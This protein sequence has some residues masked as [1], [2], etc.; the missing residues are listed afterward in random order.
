MFRQQIIKP[1]FFFYS[2][3]FE[4]QLPFESEDIPLPNNTQDESRRVDHIDTSINRSVLTP[5]KSGP[6]SAAIRQVSEHI[7][8]QCQRF[9]SKMQN[10]PINNFCNGVIHS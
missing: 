8:A 9:L 2:K 7:A 5:R 10:L 1:T 4:V 6:V 3:I